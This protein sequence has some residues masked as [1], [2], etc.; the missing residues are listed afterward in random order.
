[1]Q[2]CLKIFKASNF[3]NLKL[4]LSFNNFNTVPLKTSILKKTYERLVLSVVAATEYRNRSCLFQILVYAQPW[5]SQKY[6]NSMKIISVD[7][8]QE[9]AYFT[10]FELEQSG[11]KKKRSCFNQFQVVSVRMLFPF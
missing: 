7:D 2:L 1:M 11:R 8:D 5:L 10:S 9:I 4:L 6:G 3:S